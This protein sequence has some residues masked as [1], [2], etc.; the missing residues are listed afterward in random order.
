MKAKNKL[1]YRLTIKNLEDTLQQ[2][3]V[4]GDI[5]PA[6]FIK[7]NDNLYRLWDGII[8]NKKAVEQLFTLKN[9]TNRE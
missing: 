5:S 9:E 1:K 4:N 7:Y 8:C 2:M 6:T 3:L